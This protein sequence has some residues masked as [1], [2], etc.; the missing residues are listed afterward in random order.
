MKEGIPNEEGK[1][2]DTDNCNRRNSDLEFE[3]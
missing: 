1:R 3:N 2:I